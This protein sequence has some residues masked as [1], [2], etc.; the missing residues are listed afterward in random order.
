MLFHRIY[1]IKILPVRKLLIT[2]IVVFTCVIHAETA[3]ETS[4]TIEI[5]DGKISFYVRP[6]LVQAGHTP[7]FVGD[8]FKP[9]FE[10]YPG[11]LELG[12]STI[13]ASISTKQYRWSKPPDQFFYGRSWDEINGVPLAQD[14][15]I[16]AGYSGQPHDARRG[17]LE[18]FRIELI[19]PEHDT[20]FP[21]ELVLH[22]EYTKGEKSYTSYT[23]MTSEHRDGIYRCVLWTS[24]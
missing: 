11:L 7:T 13:Q 8:T 18:I 24:Q 20:D 21:T 3:R 6:P 23:E 12:R 9:R 16:D 4:K 19:T 5:I 1:S 17:L 22:T 14:D 10:R 2:T 15:L